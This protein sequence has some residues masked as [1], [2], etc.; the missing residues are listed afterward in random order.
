[1]ANAPGIQDHTKLLGAVGVHWWR[2]VSR[3]KYSS[4]VHSTCVSFFTIIRPKGNDPK[5]AIK[6]ELD[7]N[8]NLVQW[9]NKRK[10]RVYECEC[11]FIAE[12]PTRNVSLSQLATPLFCQ[13]DTSFFNDLLRGQITPRQDELSQPSNASMQLPPAPR[14]QEAIDP[15]GRMRQ[16]GSAPGA[17]G[18]SGSPIWGAERGPPPHP[19]PPPH[20]HPLPPATTPPH[21][22]FRPSV[23]SAQQP[24]EGPPFGMW[25]S[26][27][28][29][30]MQWRGGHEEEVLFERRRESGSLPPPMK[31]PPQ[32]AQRQSVSPP[33]G[34]GGDGGGGG[35]EFE[36]PIMAQAKALLSRVMAC[37]TPDDPQSAH[38]VRGK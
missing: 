35:E 10:V 36:N 1:M 3:C 29:S 7:R 24:S 9:L 5:L 33:G 4:E 15:W 28:S 38:I 6:S 26:K 19:T 12:L 21:L 32:V 20:H 2:Q 27:E 14:Q 30:P 16:Q 23:Q 11:L 25:N 31:M 8:V 37:R 18:K 17:A 13:F 34:G 22:A